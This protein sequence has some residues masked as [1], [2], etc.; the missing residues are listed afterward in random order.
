MKLNRMDTTR[1]TFIG[2]FDTEKIAL[3]KIVIPIIQ[4]D[5]AQGRE[6]AEISRVRIR[7][8]NSLYK[9]VQNDAITLD[10]IYG[11]VS[12]GGVMTPLDG[13][14]RL[15]TLFLLHWYAAQKE[16]IAQQEYAFLKKF[17]YE[18]RYS[19]RDFCLRLV[20]FTP[21]FTREVSDEIIDQPWFPLEWK[22]D[23]TIR[24]MLLML[25]AIV[26]KFADA[27][28]IWARL[29]DGAISFYFLPI[30]E[31]GL[32]DE[33]YIKMNS[34]GKPLTQFEHFKAEL[35]WELHNVDEE[36]AKRVIRKIDCDWT[37]ML[38]KYRGNCSVTDDCFLHYFRFICDIICYQDGDTPQGEVL[39]EFDCLKRFFSKDNED[40]LKNIRTLEEYYD[41]W[42]SL[43][44]ECTSTQFLEQFISHFHEPG[45][46]KIENHRIDIFSDCLQGY[47]DL[48]GDGHRV[49]PLNR[50]I[51]LFAIITYLRNRNT[52]SSGQFSRRLRIINNLIRNSENEISD[53]SSRAGGNRMPAILRQVSGIIA[54]GE[55]DTLLE[56]NFNAIQ[57]TEEAEKILWLNG[58]PEMSETLF[59][60]ED[61]ELLQ[62]QIGIVGLGDA[63][64]FNRF[65][66]LFAC[67]WDAVDCALMSMGNYG[68]RER[69]GWRYQLGSS[70]LPS[71]WRMLFHKGA[72]VGFECTKKILHD[73][74][75]QTEVFADDAL[76][77]I[78]EKFIKESEE[79]SFFDWRYYYVKY[80]CFRPGSHG[81]Y[82][83][84]DFKT[85]PYE[86]SVLLTAFNYSG[87]TY[88]PF[89][90]TVDADNVAGN[91]WGQ[92]IVIGKSYI[93][94]QNNAYV[95]K[96]S[97]TDEEI[98]AVPIRQNADGIDTE[99]RIQKMMGAIPNIKFYD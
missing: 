36:V 39:N 48:H 34:R 42:C 29:K 18:T 30:K 5:Y 82:H 7:F 88:Q 49:F 45:K 20:D 22:K 85:N 92:R 93:I 51:L 57:L 65:H 3:Q 72:N 96:M 4:R 10:F 77:E 16:G 98:E 41:C 71:A 89:L 81:K 99:D 6:E 95:I 19:T 23:Q 80:D 75:S 84:R 67:C 15:T 87:T 52:I 12:P 28:N 50:I 59:S 27:Q 58:H 2:I 60:L 24:S 8:L 14:Q 40:V 46:I 21:S 32:V 62:G 9:A 97:G 26:A 70:K 25:D 91:Y 33:L 69:N 73:L 94:C 78:K 43:A 90:K 17:G 1:Y 54:S 66:A 55:I 76:S 38:W 31:M 53:S 47:V 64:Y 35:E 68:Q 86:F 63:E 11:D 44:K 13:Q 61:H 79:R 83:W 56:N 74:L 37:D